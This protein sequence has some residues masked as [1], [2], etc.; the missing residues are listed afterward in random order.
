MHILAMWKLV[1][2]LTVDFQWPVDNWLGMYILEA[3][4]GAVVGVAWPL[5]SDQ[6]SSTLR[7]LNEHFRLY[8]QNPCDMGN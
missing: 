5:P 3:Q 6:A 7:I 4:D 2:G 1:C 8:Q